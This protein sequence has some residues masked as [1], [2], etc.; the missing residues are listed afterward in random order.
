MYISRTTFVAK[1]NN[2]ESSVS[3]L[4]TKRVIPPIQ[5]A[6]IYQCEQRICCSIFNLHCCKR[7]YFYIEKVSLQ[8]YAFRGLLY[9]FIR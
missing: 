8:L 4:I 9:L 3:T 6:F 7:L 1:I 5:G 2:I